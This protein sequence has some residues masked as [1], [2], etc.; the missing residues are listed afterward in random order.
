MYA[1]SDEIG[2][3][4]IVNLGDINVDGRDDGGF[5]DDDDISYIFWGTSSYS[6]VYDLFDEFPNSLNFTAIDDFGDFDITNVTA[7]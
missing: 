1:P 6:A 4:G 7:V 3:D 2:Y 5:G